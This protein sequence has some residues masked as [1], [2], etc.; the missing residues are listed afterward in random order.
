MS[1]REQVEAARGRARSAR[2]RAKARMG[3]RRRVVS[4]EFNTMNA[5]V[6]IALL[7]FVDFTSRVMLVA[8]AWI[9]A[10][11]GGGPVDHPTR[12][13]PSP[14][15]RSGKTVTTRRATGRD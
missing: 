6:G 14:A 5:G 3:E 2:E 7:L 12:D 1:A 10:A 11:A 9:G 8:A 13:L 4:A 15:R